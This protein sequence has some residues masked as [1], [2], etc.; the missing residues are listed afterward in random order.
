MVELN[1]KCFVR[2]R[3]EPNRW[4]LI[5]DVSN[6]LTALNPDVPDFQPGKIWKNETESECHHSPVIDHRLHCAYLGNQGQENQM[7][8]SER[9]QLA[10]AHEAGWNDALAKRK[11]PIKKKVRLTEEC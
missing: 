10:T 2:C 6:Q 4:P 8:D 3:T 7:N 1:D 5:A 11:K 9:E